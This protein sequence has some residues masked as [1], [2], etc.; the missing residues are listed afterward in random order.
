[1]CQLSTFCFVF[2]PQKTDFFGTNIMSDL[3]RTQGRRLR[4][5][6][7]CV[8]VRVSVYN[9]VLLSVCV[10]C[11]ISKPR[12]RGGHCPATPPARKK[13][14]FKQKDFKIGENCPPAK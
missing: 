1:M 14:D 5:V 8:L 10:L 13:A 3:R 4:L 6:L 2:L 11:N 12:L 9:C 7:F